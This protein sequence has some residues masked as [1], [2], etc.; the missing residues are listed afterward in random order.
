MLVRM[1]TLC[2]LPEDSS[3]TSALTSASAKFCGVISFMVPVSFTVQP[4][5]TVLPTKGARM[6]SASICRMS[7]VQTKVPPPI[8]APTTPSPF[9]MNDAMAVF[10]AEASVALAQSKPFKKSPA[11]SCSLVKVS[12]LSPVIMMVKPL[13]TRGKR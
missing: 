2:T 6:P 9:W 3:V 7:G 11:L 10:S 5:L 4:S 1:R 8:V 12:G 13:S